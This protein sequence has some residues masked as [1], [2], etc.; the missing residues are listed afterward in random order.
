MSAFLNDGRNPLSRLTIAAFEDM[1][2]QVHLAAAHRY[3]LPSS[4]ELAILGAG[5]LGE[6]GWPVDGAGWSEV[7]PELARVLEERGR[8][9]PDESEALKS[10]AD[11]ALQR[12]VAGDVAPEARPNVC[13]TSR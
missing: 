5:R 2:Y 1:G 3:A 7:E 9:L 10:V 4:L 12:M 11:D 6:L 13:A 8:G